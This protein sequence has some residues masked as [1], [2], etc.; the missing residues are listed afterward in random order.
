MSVQRWS[1]RDGAELPLLDHRNADYRGAKCPLVIVQ[2][3]KPSFQIWS[4]SDDVAPET[5]SK[6]VWETEPEI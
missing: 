2:R 5:M 6:N 1:D 3:E 4:D